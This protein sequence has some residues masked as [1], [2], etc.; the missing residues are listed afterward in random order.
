M[1]PSIWMN[2]LRAKHNLIL[3]HK[4]LPCKLS[5]SS[6]CSLKLRC[7]SPLLAFQ[8][9]FPNLIDLCTSFFS[10][11]STK[12]PLAV[13]GL[14]WKWAPPELPALT[15]P[16]VIKTVGFSDSEDGGLPFICKIILCPGEQPRSSQRPSLIRVYSTLETSWKRTSALFIALYPTPSTVPNM[17]QVH[18]DS[19]KIIP[20]VF[21]WTQ[22]IKWPVCLPEYSVTPSI[23]VHKQSLRKW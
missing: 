12:P 22:I 1:L 21:Y 4:T 8:L 7:Q 20:S 11:S 9:H 10:P 2:L 16:S 23:T 15:P 19:N 17:Q 3:N 6:C 18:E 13:Q 14:V 5:P